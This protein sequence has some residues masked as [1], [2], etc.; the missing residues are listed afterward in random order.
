LIHFLIK[1]IKN[2]RIYWLVENTI[3]FD[4]IEKR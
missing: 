3:K 4:I 1:I 2:T